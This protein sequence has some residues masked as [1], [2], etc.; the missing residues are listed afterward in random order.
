MQQCILQLFCEY[1]Q[2]NIKCVIFATTIITNNFYYNSL[3]SIQ[4]SITSMHDDSCIV[5][6]DA[7]GDG[8]FNWGVKSPRPSIV[9]SWVNWQEDGDDTDATKGPLNN[10]GYCEDLTAGIGDT[11][12]ID[13]D[14]STHDMFFS[15]TKICRGATLT[16]NGYNMFLGYSSITIEAGSTLIINGGKLRYA[17]IH[18][19]PQS[20]LIVQDGGE[21][22]LK[23]GKSL[24]VPIGAICDI[25][26]GA[27]YNRPYEQ[28]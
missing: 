16:L 6:E 10:Y 15:N 5:C 27:I 1:L 19:K 21:I 12:I 3:T 11:V 4:G 26:S 2:V 22:Y 14:G 7:D 25:S 17:E 24:D 18:M 23:N 28:F 9:P 13:S 8:Y 20:H